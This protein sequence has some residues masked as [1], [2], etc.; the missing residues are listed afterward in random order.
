M[1]N[2]QNLLAKLKNKNNQVIKEEPE[3]TDD[4]PSIDYNE[5]NSAFNEDNNVSNVMNNNALVN[6]DD[7]LFKN[8]DIK[9]DDFFQN[10]DEMHSFRPN[11]IVSQNFNSHKENNNNNIRQSEENIVN[12]SLAYNNSLANFD[13]FKEVELN[14]N[15]NTNYNPNTNL[16]V[17]TMNNQLNELFGRESILNYNDN[18]SE[19]VN[20]N[21]NKHEDIKFNDNIVNLLKK[22][23][24]ENKLQNNHTASDD[25][26][27]P[28]TKVNVKLSDS[29]DVE[30]IIEIPQN[31]TNTKSN[32]MN[33]GNQTY[34]ANVNS[35]VKN[36]MNFDEF[37]RVEIKV[38]NNF[39]NENKIEMNENN[40]LKED[41]KNRNINLF[42]SNKNEFK[43]VKNEEYDLKS[44]PSNIDVF[45]NLNKIKQQNNKNEFED[46]VKSIEKKNSMQ[47]E[48]LD[49]DILEK[50]Q[51]IASEYQ[52]KINTNTKIA[53]EEN[54]PTN[55]NFFTNSNFHD[56][57]SKNIGKL[58]IIFR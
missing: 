27:I 16:N 6:V 4:L 21:H 51:K 23:K 11:N 48:N 10:H 58:I 34:N 13:N 3:K 26:V 19:F 42:D 33:L 56:L 18:D 41:T 12:N 25:K 54:N 32:E 55:N 24:E 44:I 22:E 28:K 15:T 20:K 43:N 53:T 47:K 39:F 49:K 31:N 29:F 8:S 14:T 46:I 5:Q 2:L 38:K 40:N 1:S 50:K 57:N 17:N 36:N 7:S 45:N 30:E 37:D 35:N 9:K 52:N